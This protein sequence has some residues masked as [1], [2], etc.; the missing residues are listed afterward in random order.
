MKT[1]LLICAA[2]DHDMS[3]WAYEGM[4]R[5][6][7]KKA[8][9]TPLHLA[10]IAALTPDDIEVRIWDEHVMGPI[11]AGADLAGVDLV[12][13]TAFS[14]HL[15]RARK[16]AALMRAK[17]IPV[18]I[19]GPGVTSAPE[20]CRDDFDVLFVGEAET[21]WPRFIDDFRA[22]RHQREYRAS[23]PPDLALSPRPRWESIAA[24]MSE[25]ITGGV[26]VSRGCPFNC[27]FC[28]VWQIFGR[29][30]RTKDMD[31][32]ADEIRTLERLGLRSILFCS[33]NFV[34][35]PKYAKE[36][37][38]RVIALNAEFVEPIS[39][40]AELD[41]TIAR[42]DEML[43]LLA[44]ANFGGLLIGI[45][46]PNRESLA[47]VR[48]RQNLRGNL[49]ETCRRIQSFGIPIDGSVVVGFDHDTVAT[50]DEQFAF[51]QDSCIPLPK[52]HMLKAIPGTELHARLMA[53]GRVV[54][55]AT[56]ADGGSA[57]YLDAAVHSNILPVGMSRIELMAGYLD[58]V[59]RIFDW[60]NF[61][62]RTAGFVANVARP[63]RPA[64]ERPDQ[65]RVSGLLS[66]LEV[67]PAEAQEPVRRLLAETQDTAPFMAPT[68]ATLVFRQLFDAARLPA[69]R[70]EITRQIAREEAA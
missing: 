44:D 5:L 66:R 16:I 3:T 67:F 41:I 51:L 48:K 63:P 45:E 11:E 62:R 19:G 31:Q 35:N 38:R 70:N 23:E 17:A 57:D 54:D 64:V 12:G 8:F 24:T 39:F 13:V 26:Q 53:E 6:V 29:K 30:M 9:I 65:R 33:D 40:A 59:E 1:I 37:L 28:G 55:R 43:E 22:G 69:M 42:D 32:V 47:E 36:L 61:A 34:G 25:Y 46:T 49:V 27:E 68:V 52:M 4:P 60:E 56:I 10:T 2:N 15:R 21:T 50:F 7:R 20:S 18:V 58:L 14:S